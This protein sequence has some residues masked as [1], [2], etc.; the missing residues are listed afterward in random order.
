M[1][2]LE[3]KPRVSTAWCARMPNGGSRRV[4]VRK[5][6]DHY[7]CARETCTAAQD[8][9]RMRIFAA[10]E[11]GAAVD[12]AD[13]RA[14]RDAEFDVLRT[15]SD[16]EAWQFLGADDVARSALLEAD[17]EAPLPAAMLAAHTAA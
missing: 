2:D 15:Q 16:V 11:A 6:G 17:P 12:A 5:A 10:E 7:Y 4:W 13:V 14:W 8:A 9:A 1:S 3:V